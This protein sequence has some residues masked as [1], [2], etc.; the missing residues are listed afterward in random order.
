M[1]RPFGW[2]TVASYFGTGG[3]RR[4]VGSEPSTREGTIT[5][6]FDLAA[7]DELAAPR[8]V[9][10]D[11]RQWS[12]HVGVVGDDE[13]A[14]AAFERTYRIKQDYRIG[15][16]DKQSTLSKLKWETQTERYIYVGTSRAHREL[17]DY[18]GWEYRSVEE[19]ARKAEWRLLSETG[20][21]ARIQLWL[22]RS[23]HRLL[24]LF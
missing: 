7:L 19:A 10:R 15:A 8:A 9:F 20:L 1:R 11:A 14:I 24:S 17:A 12:T 23:A 2:S 3:T 6:A 16:L 4:N 13:T 22:R 5:L 18:V 21:L